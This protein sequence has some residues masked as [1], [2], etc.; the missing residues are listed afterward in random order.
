MTTQLS[1]NF[2]LDE[3]IC[4]CGCGKSNIN[5]RLIYMLQKIR[6]EWGESI[7]VTSGLRCRNHNTRI[8]G[9]PKSQHIEGTAA[10]IT[11]PGNIQTFYNFIVKMYKDGKIP[12]LGFILIYPGRNFLHVD[13]RKPTSNTVKSL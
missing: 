7:S 9:S 2:R 12:E 13:V 10:D 6:D 8:G 4:K 3:F 5:M 11:T 1:K